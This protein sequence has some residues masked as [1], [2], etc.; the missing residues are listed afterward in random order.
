MLEAVR[1]VPARESGVRAGRG[2]KAGG[3]TLVPAIIPHF[4][5]EW[6]LTVI[7]WIESG[8]VAFAPRATAFIL[9]PPTG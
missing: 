6:Q 2:F 1:T 9:S 8:T 3:G 5:W 7:M 4:V